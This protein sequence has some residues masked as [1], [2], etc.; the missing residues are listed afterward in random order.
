MTDFDE[1]NLAMKI[2][3]ID[4]DNKPIDKIL[5]G[6]LSAWDKRDSYK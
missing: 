4:K 6:R 5:S 3:A 1:L 2:S